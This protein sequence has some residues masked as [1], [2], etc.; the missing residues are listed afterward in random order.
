MYIICKFASDYL[1]KQASA[2]SLSES[3]HSY[4]HALQTASFHNLVRIKKTKFCASVLPVDFS[5]TASPTNSLS[6]CSVHE[7]Q[8]KC[9]DMLNLSWPSFSST[10]LSH[11]AQFFQN[12][13]VNVQREHRRD[14]LAATSA[15]SGRC[16][17]QAAPT[18]TLQFAMAPILTAWCL[19]GHGGIAATSRPIPWHAGQRSRYH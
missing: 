19:E 1:V 11:V 4:L 15:I 12:V 16:C 17:S 13:T 6:P 7:C 18:Q 10:S 9:H 8:S 5:R 2:L 3:L 14:S